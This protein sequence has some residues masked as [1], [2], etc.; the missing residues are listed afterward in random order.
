MEVYLVKQNMSFVAHSRAYVY[1]FA[2]LVILSDIGEG[3]GVV[4]V[5]GSLGIGL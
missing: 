5:G 4:G 1:V 3:K 2:F